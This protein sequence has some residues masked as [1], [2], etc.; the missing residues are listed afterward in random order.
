MQQLLLLQLLLCCVEG[1]QTP[2]VTLAGSL[3]L[4]ST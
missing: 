4:V 3:L 1:D 2:C